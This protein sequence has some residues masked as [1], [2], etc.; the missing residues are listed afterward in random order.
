VGEDVSGKYLSE[1]FDEFGS[2]ADF[3]AFS[4]TLKSFLRRYERWQTVRIGFLIDFAACDNFSLSNSVV[5]QF[6]K[7]RLF[8]VS[9][10]TL[11]LLACEPFRCRSSAPKIKKP[12]P[13]ASIRLKSVVNGRR[14]ACKLAFEFSVELT[15]VSE[16][17]EQ[18]ELLGSDRA[19]LSELRP[20]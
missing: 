4:G 8:S 18:I 6:S 15:Y 20:F 9:L 1:I 16:L 5:F 12:A 10:A 7:S 11:N 2:S 3:V 17:M 19:S 13:N 14:D